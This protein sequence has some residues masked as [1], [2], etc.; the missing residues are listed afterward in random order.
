MRKPNRIATMY[1]YN[2]KYPEHGIY[3]LP[4][5]DIGRVH[6]QVDNTV[7]YI[8]TITTMFDIETGEDFEYQRT[9]SIYTPYE[10]DEDMYM[11]DLPGN[12]ER[13]L[14]FDREKLE[15][16]WYEDVKTRYNIMKKRLE[17]LKECLNQK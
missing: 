9:Y 10:E 2:P 16:W 15:E 5:V 14:S 8:N 6:S 3:E 11:Y 7:N 13:I 4:L 1:C 12:R 17:D